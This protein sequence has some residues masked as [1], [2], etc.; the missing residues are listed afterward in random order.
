MRAP[1]RSFLVITHY[2]RLLDYIRPDVVHVLYKGQIVRT[3]GYELVEHIEQ[4]GFDFLKS[5]E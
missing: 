3:A 5:E 1:Y 4:N 2:K